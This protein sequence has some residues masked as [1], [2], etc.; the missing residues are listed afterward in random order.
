MKIRQLKRKSGGE[1]VPVWPPRW[2]S[3]YG[4]R[5]LFAVREE[6]VLESV[7]R[8]G[9]RLDLTM[10]YEN[11]A[12]FGGLEWTPPPAIEDVEKVLRANISRP[13]KAIS[14]LDV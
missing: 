9:D 6:G 14:E 7:T 5:D 13:I 2:A 3:S 8:R 11:L 12:H 1:D 4:R 10:R